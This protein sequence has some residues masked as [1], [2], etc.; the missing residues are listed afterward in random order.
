MYTLQ[1]VLTKKE[2]ILHSAN[3]VPALFIS[4]T[5]ASHSFIYLAD[6]TFSYVADFPFIDDQAA[7]SS[8]FRELL[9]IHK[10]LVNDSHIFAS[11]SSQLV[12]W[13]TD[14]QAC[15]LGSSDFGIRCCFTIGM[16]K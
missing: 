9:A 6:G 11:F 13:Q 12:Y 16:I 1:D 4:D 14:N 3:P 10:A 2:D 15:V 7:A 5:S 8:S